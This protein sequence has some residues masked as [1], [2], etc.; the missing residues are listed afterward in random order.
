MANINWESGI[1]GMI[2]REEWLSIPFT[3]PTIGTDPIDTLFANEKTD[4]IVARWNSI[5]YDQLIPAMAQFHA[6][7]VEARKTV[8][9]VLENHMVEKGL[10]KVKLNQ[11]ERLQAL[12]RDGVRGDEAIYREVLND[13]TRLSRQVDTRVR[14]AKNELLATGEMTIAENGLNANIDFGVTAAQKAFTID[15]AKTADV[16]AQIQA[17]IDTARENGVILNGVIMTGRNMTKLRSNQAIQ[18]AKNGTNR[19]G[20]LLS[21]SELRAYLSDEFGLTNIIVQDNIYNANNEQIGTDG[22]LIV[23]TRR[24]FPHE[25]ITFFATQPNGRLGIGLYGDP[26]SVVNPLISASSANGVS[27]FVYIDQWTE[28][29]PAVLWTRASALFIPVL[30]NPSTLYIATASDSGA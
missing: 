20:A 12:T 2:S 5:S 9:P 6:F 22:K 29:D 8:R 24:Y 26:P 25:K 14:V 18:I 21:N 15:L 16:P 13:A 3:P 27:P 1:F 4:N 23:T 30:Y 17:I 10:I 28:N 11:S 7:D 19:S